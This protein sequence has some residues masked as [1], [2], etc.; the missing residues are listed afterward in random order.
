VEVNGT[1]VARHELV[2]GDRL[3]V[4]STKL[5][6]RTQGVSAGGFGGAAQPSGSVPPATSPATAASM[7]AATPWSQGATV[8]QPAPR[9]PP[10][11]PPP[12]PPPPRKA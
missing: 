5:I 2:G 9:K 1:V 8:T 4:G 12:P 11:P 3:R 10:A 6:F 7:N